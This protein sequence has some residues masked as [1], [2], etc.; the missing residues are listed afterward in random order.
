M[1]DWVEINKDEKHVSRERNKARE[2]RASAWW[3]NE[4]AKGICYYCKQQFPPDEL[5]MDHILPVARGGKSQ[6]GNVVTCCKQCNNAKSHL[7]PAEII[8]RQLEEQDRQ[9]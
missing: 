6:R 5:T 3:K 8:L 9:A 7:T 1:S 2:L 4:L